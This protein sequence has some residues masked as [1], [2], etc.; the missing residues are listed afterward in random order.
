MRSGNERFLAEDFLVEFSR[1][2][3]SAQLNERP[4]LGWRGDGPTELDERDGGVNGC[5]HR[6]MKMGMRR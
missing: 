3:R 2:G 6:L 5:S 1:G 4:G